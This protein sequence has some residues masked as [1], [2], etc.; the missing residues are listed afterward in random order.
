MEDL[1]IV[2]KLSAWALLAHIAGQVTPLL[3]WADLPVRAVRNYSGD[4]NT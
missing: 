1:R 3:A 4:G 2:R